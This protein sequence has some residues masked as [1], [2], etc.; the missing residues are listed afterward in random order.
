[1]NKANEL[2]TFWAQL[3]PTEIAFADESHEVNFRELDMYTRKIGF[4]LK[5]TGIKRG[6]IV[7]LILPGYLGW[8]FSLSL[9]RMG[10]TTMMKNNLSDFSPE[11]IPDWLIALEKHPGKNLDRTIIVDEEYLAKVNAT[12]ELEEFEGFASGDEISTF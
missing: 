8:L 11:L 3:K 10:V 2:I 5:E 12:K 4:L 7:G 1:M 9:N 6:D